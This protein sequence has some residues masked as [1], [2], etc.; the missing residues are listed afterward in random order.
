MSVGRTPEHTPEQCVKGA[1]MIEA[2][3]DSGFFLQRGSRRDI[4]I[5][6]WGWLS[7]R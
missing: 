1:Y 3:L 2:G 5:Y 6:T 7:Y 4:S